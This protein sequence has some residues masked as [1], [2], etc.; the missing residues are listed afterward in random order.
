[1]RFFMK[2]SVRRRKNKN[3]CG[4]KNDG[5]PNN[6]STYVEYESIPKDIKDQVRRM[7]HDA[8]KGKN[9]D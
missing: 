8:A 6:R 7:I 5:T 3:P 4:V 9:S 2:K 1:M